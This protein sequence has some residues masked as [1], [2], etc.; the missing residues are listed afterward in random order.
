MVGVGGLFRW[1]APY[2]LGQ[3]RGGASACP[4][5]VARLTQ[6]WWRRCLPSRKLSSADSASPPFLPLELR[7]IPLAV[8]QGSGRFT[9]A[10][11]VGLVEE[12]L[13]ALS[14]VLGHQPFLLGSAPLEADASAFGLLHV[15][16][17]HKGAVPQ[18][19]TLVRLGWCRIWC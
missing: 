4:R 11:L 10:E 8:E 6:R 13:D 12:S 16:L 2:F 18:L 3:L 9:E 14:A 7:Y 15:L 5:P 1:K 17:R 19:E